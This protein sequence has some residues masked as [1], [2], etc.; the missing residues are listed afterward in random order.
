M[1]LQSLEW[2]EVGLKLLWLV[3]SFKTYWCDQ[4]LCCQNVNNGFHMPQIPLHQTLHSLT[5]QEAPENISMNAQSFLFTHPSGV[6][7]VWHWASNGQFTLCGTTSVSLSSRVCSSRMVVVHLAHLALRTIQIGVPSLGV[8]RKMVLVG[9]SGVY[10]L[11][12]S[13]HGRKGHL[14]QPGTP[15]HMI[16]PPTS[17][18][19]SSISYRHQL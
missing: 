3:I 13:S 18:S 12:V 7:P 19:L 16:P 8:M 10:C 5:S 14:W 17:P 9:E 1:S 4:Y 2:K 11:L 6:L 15:L